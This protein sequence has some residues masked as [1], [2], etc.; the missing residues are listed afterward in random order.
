M[1]SSLNRA[2]GNCCPLYRKKAR[3][4]APRE[5]LSCP[6][7]GL[8]LPPSSSSPRSGPLLDRMRPGSRNVRL[9][10]SPF[11]PRYLAMLGKA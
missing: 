1:T 7:A 10:S 8:P 6:V 11:Y 4:L 5:C 9:S 3:T 2:R